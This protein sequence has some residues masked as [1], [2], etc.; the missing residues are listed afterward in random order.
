MAAFLCVMLLLLLLLN[1]VQAHVVAQLL[2]LETV[3][4]C[5]IGLDHESASCSAI[6]HLAR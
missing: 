2:L 5:L 6:C 4:G 1:S 3:V